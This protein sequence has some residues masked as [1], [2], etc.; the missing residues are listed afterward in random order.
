MIKLQRLS[1]HVGVDSRCNLLYLYAVAVLY[2]V[3][4][5]CHNC[6]RMQYLPFVWAVLRVLRA[7]PWSC[8]A[9]VRWCHWGKVM[10]WHRGFGMLLAGSLRCTYSWQP[11][12]FRRRGSFC[13]RVLSDG[14]RFLRGY[15]PRVAFRRQGSASCCPIWCRHTWWPCL[16][17]TIRYTLGIV[18]KY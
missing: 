14:S 2:L 10:D 7:F 11:H 16:S 6:F 9:S 3:T 15:Y 13:V 5:F 4:Q 8:M 12:G 17:V 1:L 18:V